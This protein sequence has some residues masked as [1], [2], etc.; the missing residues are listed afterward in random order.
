MAECLQLAQPNP[1]RNQ[2]EPRLVGKFII[3]L[4][5]DWVVFDLMTLASVEVQLVGRSVVA[6]LFATD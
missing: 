4:L 2:V 1:L 3:A 6:K 5:R